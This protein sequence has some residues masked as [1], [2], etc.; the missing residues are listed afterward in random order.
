MMS[1]SMPHRLFAAAAAA[2]A[3]GWKGWLMCGLVVT[4]GLLLCGVAVA[5][6]RVFFEY[7]QA[8]RWSEIWGRT[9]ARVYY[10]LIGLILT[11]AGL[12]LAAWEAGV[13]NP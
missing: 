3:G 11:V 4:I 5:N 8:A 12:A 10:F 1:F 7:G 6:A 2:E 9:G 13:I